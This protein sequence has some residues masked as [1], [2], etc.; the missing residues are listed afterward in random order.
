MLE[1]VGGHALRKMRLNC[2]LRHGP[3]ISGL[4][5][6]QA[7]Y[8]GRGQEEEVSKGPLPRTVCAIFIWVSHEG[9]YV[10]CRPL[11]AITLG[12]TCR[13]F[14]SRAEATFLDQLKFRNYTPIIW[15]FF[16]GLLARFIVIVTRK[17]CITRASIPNQTA[18]NMVSIVQSMKNSK[19]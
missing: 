18:R 14:T 12:G 5:G 16:F 11:F 19:L 10:H 8:L 1:G 2:E 7:C 9:G 17:F 6:C 4:F 15:F 13:W 3:T